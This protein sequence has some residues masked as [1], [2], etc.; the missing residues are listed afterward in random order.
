VPE[1][2]IITVVSGLPRSGTSMMMRMLEAAGLSI[3]TDGLRAPDAD[4]PRGYYEFE[5]VKKLES[6][7]AWLPEAR[8]RVVKIV[9]PLLKHL[10]PGHR[11]KVVF[12]RRRMEEVLAS[13]RQMLVRRGRTEDGDP[14]AMGEVF[15]RHLDRV[16]AWLEHQAHVDVLYVDYNALVAGAG[17][18]LE[19]LQTFL[20]GDLQVDRMA[21]VIERTLHRQRTG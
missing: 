7:A 1:T 13:Q 15:R 3:L 5:R 17:D 9:S 16:E 10:P 14:A 6:D 8:G 4:N 2:E 12:M 21:E 11:Y 19:R 20:G 18:D